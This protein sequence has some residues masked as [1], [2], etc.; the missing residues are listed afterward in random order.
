MTHVTHRTYSTHWI[1]GPLVSHQEVNVVF[2]RGMSLD[3]LT[4]E[5]LSM[6][7]IPLAY[8]K[9]AE[10]EWGLVMHDMFG[11][12]EDDYDRPDYRPLCRDG[13]ELAVFTTEPCVAKAHGPDFAYLRDGRFVCGFSFE[14]LSYGVGD[15]PDLLS[16]ALT[17]AR[18]IGPRAEYDRE[19]REERTVR[20]ISSFFSLPDPDF[21][22]T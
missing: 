14:T 3:A 2:F 9:G 15:H 8:A 16:P 18:L 20:A 17:A 22:L 1:H 5:L 13:G 11:W 19:D 10:G 21:S 12:D 6:R 4:R 7:R